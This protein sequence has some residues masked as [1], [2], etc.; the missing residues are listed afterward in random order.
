MGLQKGTAVLRQVGTKE[1]SLTK[2]RVYLSALAVIGIILLPVEL[3]NVVMN[4]GDQK[5]ETSK[6]DGRNAEKDFADA[7]NAANIQE[8]N[9]AK[10]LDK[11]EGQMNNGELGGGM[12]KEEDIRE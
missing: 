11:T 5:N 2:Q 7:N 6:A 10:P 3:K 1:K 4:Q 8:D 12:K 9:E